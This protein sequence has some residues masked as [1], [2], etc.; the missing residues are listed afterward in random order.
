MR[1]VAHAHAVSTPVWVLV[2]YVCIVVLYMDGEIGY[3][4]GIPI[5]LPL[6]RVQNAPV[7]EVLS[8]ATLL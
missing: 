6:Y 8:A 3:T 2:C 1:W 4:G 7:L 5:S